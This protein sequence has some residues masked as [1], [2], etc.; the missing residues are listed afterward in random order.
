[1]PRNPFK[2]GEKDREPPG[3]GG[4]LTP[5]DRGAEPTSGSGGLGAVPAGGLGPTVPAGSAEPYA[6]GATTAPAPPQQ[7]PAGGGNVRR[8]D[9]DPVTR[10]GGALS[11]HAVADLDSRQVHEP[12][13]MATLFRGYEVILQGRDPQDAIFIS[14][15]AC[16][17]CG[18]AHAMTSALALEMAFG[19]QPPPM[20]IL[21]RNML[22]ALESLADHP[23]HLFVLAGPDF[24]EPRV[25]ATSPA[26]WERAAG[27]PAPNAGTHGFGSIGQLMTAM[28]RPS[29]QLYREALQMSRV[30]REAYV[31]IGGKIPHPQTIVP[32]GISATMDT[33]TLNEVLLRAV[34]FL[35]YSRKVAAIWDDLVDF[36]YEA[37]PRYREV[38]ARP[39]NLIDLG[40]WDDPEAYDATLENSAAWGE[41]RWGTPG[42]IVDGRLATTSL[43]ALNAAV[44]EFVHHSFYED[45]TASRNGSSHFTS[46]PVG[47]RLSAHHPW[48]KQ[49]LPAPG[50]PDGRGRYSWSTA[51]RWDRRAMETGPHARLWTTA[52]ARKS[53]HRRFMESTGQ[54][55]K[56][57]FPQGALPQAELE[58]HVPES[59]GAFERNRARAWALLYTSLVAYDNVLLGLDLMRK[60]QDRRSAP[61]KIPKDSRQGVGLGGTGRGYCSHYVSL[62]NQVIQSY[63]ILAPSTFVA[64]PRDAVGNPGPL[65]EAVGATPL[66]DYE[67][68]DDFIDVLRT[69]R[70]F[71]L[72]M[73]CATH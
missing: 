35:D 21:M 57:A 18:G 67:R 39:R 66:L 6:P 63:Q 41:A 72:C 33:Q 29:G 31:V 30:A 2:R 7:A 40:Q 27:T 43:P 54:S 36:F 51:P 64:S 65:E 60:G 62:D 59:W 13:A 5:P 3:G 61:Y 15:R 56:M 68:P 73:A 53:P 24:S 17:I 37:D 50:S 9:F 49:T 47:N 28:T 23:V 25:R 11:F 8:I 16:G 12:T 71:D 1:M 45:W 46:D 42:A 38:G 34:K 26:L 48:N 70:S 19:L 14:S 69:I 58:W 55:L 4:Y 10:V 32:G 20:A 44:E 52:L 22:L